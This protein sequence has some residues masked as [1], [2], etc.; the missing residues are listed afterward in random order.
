MSTLNEL[1]TFCNNLGKA[2][3]KM[4][5]DTEKR[6]GS[7]EKE[8]KSLKLKNIKIEKDIN[9]WDTEDLEE[10]LLNNEKKFGTFQTSLDNVI[11]DIKSS[12]ITRDTEIQNILNEKEGLTV[13][14]V[15]IEEKI[16]C[17]GKELQK[18]QPS[19]KVLYPQRY[20]CKQCGDTFPKLST[21]ELHIEDLHEK[22]ARNVRLV[23]TQVSD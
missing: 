19:T 6:L 5:E 12:S 3:R 14:L 9:N 13:K 10:R 8:I 7:L 2:F 23:F 4:T 16:K 1:T 22:S 20:K 15:N 11:D 17:L 21:L 18:M